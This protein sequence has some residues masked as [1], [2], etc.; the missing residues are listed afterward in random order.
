MN[1]LQDIRSWALALLLAPAAL[2]AQD[3]KSEPEAPKYGWSGKGEFG[4]VS[5]SGNSDTFSLNLAAE[6]AYESEKWRHR[7]AASA[8]NSE[9]NGDT[10]AKRYDLGEQSDYKLNA[11]SYVFGAL[12]YDHDDFSAYEDQ[13]QSPPVTAARFWTLKRRN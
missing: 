8:L 12:R 10:T 13:E 3:A 5:T 4:L 7:F 9:N 11:K 1:V 6:I 2:M